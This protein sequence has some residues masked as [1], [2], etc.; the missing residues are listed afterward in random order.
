MRCCF[1]FGAP[2]GLPL[3]FCRAPCLFGT[4]QIGLVVGLLLGACLLVFMLLAR[5]LKGVRRLVLCGWNIARAV[6]PGFD[7]GGRVDWISGS[8]GGVKRVR[9]NR[10]TPVH[11]VRHCILGI[12]P[13]PRIWKRLRVQDHISRDRADAKASRVHQDDEAFDSVQDRTGVG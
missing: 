12:Q 3:L 5:L 4:V 9:L 8:G 10:K 13:R 6:L 2:Q 7:G 11:L 1:Y